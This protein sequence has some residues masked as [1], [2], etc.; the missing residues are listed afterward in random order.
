MIFKFL[1]SIVRVE[2][3]RDVR[4]RADFAQFYEGKS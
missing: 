3:E 1:S 4:K 2:R